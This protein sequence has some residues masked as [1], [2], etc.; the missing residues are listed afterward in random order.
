MPKKC[1]VCGEEEAKFVIK[2]TNNYYCED[3]AKEMFND[4]SL[5]QSVEEQA[6]QLKKEIDE[7]TEDSSD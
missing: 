2:D 5:L 4:I 7:H 6:K 1:T 3:C